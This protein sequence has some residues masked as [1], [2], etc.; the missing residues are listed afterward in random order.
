MTNSGDRFWE[1]RMPVKRLFALIICFCLLLPQASAAEGE[2]LEKT[3]DRYIRGN[4][5]TE[6]NFAVSYY[7]TVSGE[8]F[9]FNEDAFFP[10]G[11]VWTLILHMYYCQEESLGAFDPPDYDPGFVYTIGG[12]TLEECR[13]ES[14]LRDNTGV[15]E[16]MLRNVGSLS[17]FQTTVN[18]RFGQVPDPPEAFVTGKNYSTRFLMNCMKELSRNNDVY[19]SLMR[20]F[21][22]VQTSDAFN[23]YSRPYSMTQVRGEEDGMICAVAEVSA[24]EPYLIVGFASEEAGGDQILAGLNDLICTYVEV[25]SD[26]ESTTRSGAPVSRRSDSDFQVSAPEQKPVVLWIGLAAG[27]AVILIILLCLLI[28]LK[29]RKN[30][31]Y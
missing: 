25:H 30:R 12:K 4:G 8:S 17:Q 2:S 20:N 28:W 10:A 18:D 14:I 23:G 13:T 24:P 3:L 27:G 9:G 7:N 16:E 15:E 11:R 6:E 19:G 21:A 29:R 26:T 5:L 1:G 22:M 31:P